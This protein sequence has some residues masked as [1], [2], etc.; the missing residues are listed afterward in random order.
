MATDLITPVGDISQKIVKLNNTSTTEDLATK[1]K[2][3]NKEVQSL[4]SEDE[5]SKHSFPALSVFDEND[6]GKVD[7]QDIMI[8]Y[9]LNTDRVATPTPAHGVAPVEK[10][11]EVVQTPEILS[12]VSV[13]A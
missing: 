5:A 13:L 10:Y 7:A 3:L 4:G 6:D 2:T 9:F 8:G 1:I 12:D 11:N